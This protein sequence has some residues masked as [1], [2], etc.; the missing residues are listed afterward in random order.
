VNPGLR[1]STS[2]LAS[3]STV[4]EHVQRPERMASIESGEPRTRDASPGAWQPSLENNDCY[5]ANE[6]QHASDAITSYRLS[7]QTTTFSTIVN[8]TS[9]ET[10]VNSS[11]CRLDFVLED[12][13][14]NSFIIYT[15]HMGYL[16][17]KMSFFFIKISYVQ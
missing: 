11:V 14:P 10:V 16:F 7:S 6:S 4:S 13:V 15:V 3:N 5:E 8:P 9:S 12:K 17:F 2:G 1:T